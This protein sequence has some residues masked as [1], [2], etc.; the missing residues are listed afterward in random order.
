M[1]AIAI[2]AIVFVIGLIG[3]VWAYA[4]PSASNW[5]VVYIFA[6]II[7]AIGFGVTL[8]LSIVGG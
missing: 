6:F 7:G 3:S 1:S 2:F 4:K 5:E 8:I